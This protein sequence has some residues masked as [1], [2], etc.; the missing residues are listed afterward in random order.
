MRLSNRPISFP[1]RAG[2][3]C[4]SFHP[5]QVF[6][7]GNLQ[8]YRYFILLSSKTRIFY[9]SFYFDAGPCPAGQV[10]SVLENGFGCA[11]AQCQVS[12]QESLLQQLVP[13]GDGLCYPLGTR[14]PCS[15]PSE[16]LGYDVLGKES[17]CVNVNDPL[18]PYFESS[19]L[20]GLLDT[21][22]KQRNPDF[23]DFEITFIKQNLLKFNSLSTRRQ[24]L[25]TIG[26]FQFP[27][28]SP[29]TLLNPCRPGPKRGNNYKCANPLV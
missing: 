14:G 25:N 10:F 15:A 20:N 6:I 24:N 5:R 21:M 12:Q 2:Q 28:F 13:G 7:H 27:N 8:F 16:L 29:K 1:N 17:A 23:G 19:E 18:S 4:S 9:S 22:H 26:V 3:L 11:P